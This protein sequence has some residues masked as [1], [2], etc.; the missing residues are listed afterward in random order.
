M[1]EEKAGKRGLF[2]FFLFRKTP[3]NRPV[4][5]WIWNFLCIT[6]ASVATGVVSLMLAY[7]NYPFGIFKGYFKVPLIAV[8]NI[9]PVL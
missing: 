4:V 6:A 3:E 2:S 5:F 1:I 9:L 8:L 7:G